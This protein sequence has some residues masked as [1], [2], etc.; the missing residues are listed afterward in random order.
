MGTKAPGGGKIENSG[1]TFWAL[2]GGMPEA[3]GW[4][5]QALLAFDQL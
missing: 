5:G 2:P 1:G 4:M 3:G